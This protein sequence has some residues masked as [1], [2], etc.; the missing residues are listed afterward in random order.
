MWHFNGSVRWIWW[1]FLPSIS[2][3]KCLF[4]PIMQTHW[5]QL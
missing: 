3:C 4:N 2:V 1:F 5:L